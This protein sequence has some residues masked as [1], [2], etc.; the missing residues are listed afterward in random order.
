LAS[1]PTEWLLLSRTILSIVKSAVDFWLLEKLLLLGTTMEYC[2]F[3]LKACN[4][5][6]M[7]QNPQT[8]ASEAETCLHLQKNLGYF[9][10]WQW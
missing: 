6:G 7:Q 4:N 3:K 10:F 2:T 9:R 5:S 8:Q 1:L